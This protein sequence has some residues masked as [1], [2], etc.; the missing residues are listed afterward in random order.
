MTLTFMYVSVCIAWL[1][2]CQLHS[3]PFPTLQDPI[4]LARIWPG[5][6]TLSLKTAG[7]PG[8]RRAALSAHT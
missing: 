3:S 1:Y 5:Q 2:S 6:L 8:K 7:F 4:A